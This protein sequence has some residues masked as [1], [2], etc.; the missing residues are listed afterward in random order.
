MFAASV[1]SVR[2]ETVRRPRGSREGERHQKQREMSGFKTGFD[3][4]KTASAEA[5][6]QQLERLRAKLNQVDPEKVKARMAIEAARE[7]REAKKRAEREA[8]LEAERAAKAAREAEEAAR[9]EAE[10]LAAE[11]AKEAESA[12]ERARKAALEELRASQ[13]AARDARY[14]ARKNRKRRG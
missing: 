3:D 6:R 9:R 8:A 7:E 4:R 11:A 5:K 13:K 14:A 2:T 1:L 12:E 10:R